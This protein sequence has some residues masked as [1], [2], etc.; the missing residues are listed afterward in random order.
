MRCASEHSFGTIKRTT[1]GGLSRCLKKVR[2]EA[3]FSVLTY[4]IMRAINF[5]CAARF[6]PASSKPNQ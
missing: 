5:V 2:A 4:N 3:A 1:A 6:D